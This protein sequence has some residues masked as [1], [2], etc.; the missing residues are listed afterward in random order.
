MRIQKVV[1]L[2]PRRSVVTLHWFWPTIRCRVLNEHDFNG[3]I[4][5]FNAVTTDENFLQ[6]LQVLHH[7]DFNACFNEVRGRWISHRCQQLRT[8]WRWLF[9]LHLWKNTWRVLSYSSRVSA[10]GDLGTKTFFV[11]K[12]ENGSTM[13]Y[14]VIK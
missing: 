7:N 3:I 13:L 6:N 4:V 10:V 1:T 5:F 8:P 2:T 9:A 11:N 12:E 14:Q